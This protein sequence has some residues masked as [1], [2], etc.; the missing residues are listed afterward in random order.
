MRGTGGQVWR[1]PAK[2]AAISALACAARSRPTRRDH[3][4]LSARAAHRVCR[5]S[6]NGCDG[7]ALTRS[8]TRSPGCRDGFRSVLST[9]SKTSMTVRLIAGSCRAAA[10]D[11][12]LEMLL[13]PRHQLDEVARAEAVVE[14]VHEDALPGVAAGAGR[15]RQR[16]EVSTACDPGRRPTLDRRGPD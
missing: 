1:L 13:Q 3:W 2:A 7:R 10:S 11:L 16:E 8:Q 15:S 14:L 6:S 5:R 9:G 4:C 12:F